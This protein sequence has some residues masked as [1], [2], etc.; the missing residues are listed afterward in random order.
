MPTQL[1]TEPSP[2]G[3]AS[4]R[5]MTT[6]SIRPRASRTRGILLLIAWL[7]SL[8]AVGAELSLDQAAAQVR[9]ETGGK[10]IS[11]RTIQAGDRRLHQIRILTTGGRVRDIHIDARAGGPP[12][13][14]PKKR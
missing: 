13:Q 2:P 10:V 5:K 14:R 11:A 1:A 12:R 4:D 8:A 6:E 7:L 9:R 3:R